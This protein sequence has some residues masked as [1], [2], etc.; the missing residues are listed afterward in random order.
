[1]GPEIA[2]MYWKVALSPRFKGKTSFMGVASYSAAGV[3]ATAAYLREVINYSGASLI[4]TLGT[5]ADRC[6]RSRFI[7]AGYSQG[8]Y[9][10]RAAL[11]TMETGKSGYE[12]YLPRISAAVV[13]ADPGHPNAGILYLLRAIAA[14]QGIF[15]ALGAVYATVRKYKRIP[16]I[17]NLLAIAPLA[18]S[19]RIAGTPTSVPFQ[20]VGLPDDIVGQ[21]YAALNVYVPIWRDV[22]LYNTLGGQFDVLADQANQALRVLERAVEYHSMYRDRPTYIHDNMSQWV[23][24]NAR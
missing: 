3:D 14:K 10:V 23:I 15:S 20:S 12:R 7:L 21:G 8:A 2:N 6:P 19:H 9:A 24:A 11:V 4:T 16:L 17:E 22:F 13:L 1:M 5:V 18:R